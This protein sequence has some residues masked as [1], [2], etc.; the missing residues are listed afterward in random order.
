[1]LNKLRDRRVC[2]YVC[3]YHETN[4]ESTLAIIKGEDIHFGPLKM[5]GARMESMAH[6]NLGKRQHMKEEN[7]NRNR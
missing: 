4:T 5:D 1:M 3:W 6:P 7:N 2:G